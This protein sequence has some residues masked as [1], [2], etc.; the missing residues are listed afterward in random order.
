METDETQQVDA[1]RI[2]R[3]VQRL[4][5]MMALVFGTL[6]GLSYLFLGRLHEMWPMFDKEFP[7]LLP[8][9]LGV[10]KGTMKPIVGML[11]AFMDGALVAFTVSGLFVLITR[12]RWR[13]NNLHSS[14]GLT[15][16]ITTGILVLF[17]IVA[18]GC[19]N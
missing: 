16:L 6:W 19:P 5:F 12:N 17:A 1:N 9:L 8:S 11:F 18:R 3:T 15:A 13:G 7:F 14:R 2:Q 10:H 4:P